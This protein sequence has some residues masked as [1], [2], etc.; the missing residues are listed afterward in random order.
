M[1][2]PKKM[3]R[4]VVASNQME[5]TKSYL[6]RGRRFEHMPV[7]TLNANWADTFNLLCL[8]RD[9]RR[10]T[11]LNDYGAELRLRGL[12]TPDHLVQDVMKQIQRRIIENPA[13]CDS[14]LEDLG[15]FVDDI[16]K[17]KH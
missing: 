15:R 13:A 2:D 6:E 8:P 7:E 16:D 14:L 12:E 17:P 4:A 1:D 5:Q 11:D 3:A 9:Q 10:P